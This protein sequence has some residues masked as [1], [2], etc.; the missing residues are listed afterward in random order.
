MSWTLLNL[1]TGF[2]ITIRNPTPGDTIR[3]ERR[4]AVGETEGGRIFAQDLGITDRFLDGSWEGVTRCE[5]DELVAFMESVKYRALAFKLSTTEG[6]AQVPALANPADWTGRVRFEQSRLE[7]RVTGTDAARSGVDERYEF[8]LKLR[9][10]PLPEILVAD[11]VTIA[12]NL[13]HAL[14]GAILSQA[15]DSLLVSDNAAAVLS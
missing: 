4:Q 14:N 6:G 3:R 10:V 9:L 12:D 2:E 1:Q 5:F 7:G 15:S 11:S 8:T 13:V